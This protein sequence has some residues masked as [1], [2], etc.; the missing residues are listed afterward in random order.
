MLSI[1]R[2]TLTQLAAQRTFS[3]SGSASGVDVPRLAIEYE[4]R[5]NPTWPMPGAEDCL[6]A[7]AA[8]Q[9]R[10]GIVS[11][12]QF[13]TE[14]L[15]PAFFH[16]TLGELGFDPRLQFYSYRHLWAKPGLHLYELAAS[17]LLQQGVPAH[18]VLYIGND[19][20]NDVAAASRVG[21]RTALFAGDAQ[22]AAA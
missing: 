3:T 5:I 2:Q 7:L 22:P 1:W 15:F 18:N 19:M 17:E 21:F 8:R 12:A 13:F 6:R 10:L 9:K 4:M 11:N 20:L 16:Q 14:F